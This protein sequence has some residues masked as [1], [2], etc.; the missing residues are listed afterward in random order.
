ML[1]PPKASGGG[2][3]DG[4]SVQMPAKSVYGARSL[5]YQIISVIGQQSNFLNWSVQGGH[6]Q[7]WFPQRG[8]G[9]GQCVDGV[10]PAKRAGTVAGIRALDMESY[11]LRGQ[12]RVL[13]S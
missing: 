9:N 13:T 3:Q 12:G 11:V 8:A 2:S 10:R 5:C 1:G 4:S 7:V 6:R